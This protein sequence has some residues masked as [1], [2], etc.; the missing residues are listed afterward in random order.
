MPFISKNK[1][2]FECVLMGFVSMLSCL[3]LYKIVYYSEK[4]VDNDN[5]ENND[6]IVSTNYHLTE[7]KDYKIFFQ[8]R[9]SRNNLIMAF[10]FGALIHYIVEQSKLTD[11]YCKKVCYDD[12]CFMVCELNSHN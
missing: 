6:N 5:S 9:E 10:L 11:M 3:L 8:M 4:Q 2:Y 7:F 1:I 12:K